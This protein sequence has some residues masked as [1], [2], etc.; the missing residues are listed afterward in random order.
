MTRATPERSVQRAIL[1]WLRLAVPDAIV[2]AVPNGSKRDAITGAILKSEGVQAGAP[3]LVFACRGIIGFIE[4]KAAK[5]RL[6]PAQTAFRDACA[7]NLLPYGVV[8]GIGDVQAFLDDLGVKTR[9]AA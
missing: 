1:Q 2:F 5:G 4:V 9:V 7:A 3:D 6:S 8:R